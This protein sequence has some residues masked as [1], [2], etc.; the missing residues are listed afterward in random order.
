MEINQLIEKFLMGKCSSEEI[1]ILNDFFKK[2]K[3]TALDKDFLKTWQTKNN[4]VSL[5]LR[6]EAIWSK[7]KN[8]LETEEDEVL[9]PL[10]KK[11]FSTIL[12]YAAIFVGIIS[13]VFYV[14]N[15]NKVDKT[16][17][18]EELVKIQLSDG[19]V[20]KIVY[21][22]NIDTLKLNKKRLATQKGNQLIYFNNYKEDKI[23]K[24]SYNKLMVPHGK[25]FQVILSDGSQVY[26]NSGSSLK[27]PVEFIKGQKREVFLKGEGYFK[28]SKNKEDAFIVNANKIQ[29]K[30]YGT[31]FNISSYENE[32]N[33]NIVL[34]EGSIGVL[35]TAIENKENKLKPNQ[36]ASYSKENTKIKIDKVEVD[37]HIAW[38]DNILLFKNEKFSIILKKL[39]R[40]YGVVFIYD[41]K[42]FKD[43]RLT[44]R[45]ETESITD[46]LS[47]MNKILDF[48]FI[49]TKNQITINPLIK[50][51]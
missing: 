40:H 42:N 11:R 30:V 50:K 27:Y 34:V 33:I 5:K 19:S 18:K 2:K 7:L 37:S 45:L 8:K 23:A 9:R 24:L 36:I 22:I 25:K 48:K 10:K 6:E 13:T 39:E 31:E 12:K 29:T 38:V 51:E 43:E 1:S 35:N 16:L 15:T 21:R 26:L 47:T 44:G 3:V 20:K 28:I 14:S 17:L 49:K 46:V 32:E 41:E 4:G